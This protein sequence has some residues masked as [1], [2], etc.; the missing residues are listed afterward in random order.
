MP[1]IHARNNSLGSARS[2]FSTL[3]NTSSPVKSKAEVGYAPSF[4]QLDM[5][6]KKKL[7]QQERDS[8]RRDI[9]ILQDIKR[10][11]KELEREQDLAN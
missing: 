6:Y 3:Q 5:I 10:R 11:Q 8:Q 4:H 1:P 2:G 7:K 9:S